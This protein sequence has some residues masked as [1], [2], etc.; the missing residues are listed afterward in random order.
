[1]E[2]RASATTERTARQQRGGRR[3]VDVAALTVRRQA[4]SARRRAA[5]DGYTRARPSGDVDDRAPEAARDRR[6]CRTRCKH[7][8]GRRHARRGR[9]RNEEQDGRRALVAELLQAIGTRNRN[10][11]HT[12]GEDVDNYGRREG[13]KPRRLWDRRRERGDEF[14]LRECLVLQ[15]AL[16]RRYYRG[17]APRVAMDRAE[18]VAAC[19]NGRTPCRPSSA[20]C[21]EVEPQTLLRTRRVKDHTNTICSR[22]CGL[23][24]TVLRAREYAVRDPR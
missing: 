12:V 7:V 10:D 23:V 15:P 24:R 8:D 5:S 19:G 20:D 18:I 22:S 4:R 14:G 9:A 16:K 11:V 21:L 1:M 3:R 13:P 2:R 6:R 17:V